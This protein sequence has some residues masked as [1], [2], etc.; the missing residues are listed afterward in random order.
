MLSNA[1]GKPLSCAFK[2]KWDVDYLFRELPD[3]ADT[4][5][6]GPGVICPTCEISCC[7]NFQKD[8]AR[9]NTTFKLTD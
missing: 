6:G 3:D 9:W 5:C 2:I 1:D 7:K 8:K 4:V